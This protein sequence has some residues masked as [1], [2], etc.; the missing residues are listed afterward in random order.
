MGDGGDNIINLIRREAEFKDTYNQA[1]PGSRTAQRQADDREGVSPL[2]GSE[3]WAKKLGKTL[4]EAFSS[5][6]DETGRSAAIDSLMTRIGNMSEEEANA[7]M[8]SGKME[9]V[10]NKILEATKPLT[11]KL[12]NVNMSSSE[13]SGRAADT[14]YE[15]GTSYPGVEGMLGRMF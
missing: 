12:P 4:K 1:T 9:K 6:L 14:L 3:G 7:F 11:D 13:F 8:A 5:E 2:E 10:F 15:R